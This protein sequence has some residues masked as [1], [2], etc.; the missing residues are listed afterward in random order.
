MCYETQMPPYE[1]NSRVAI[2]VK[3]QGQDFKIYGSN[4]KVLSQVTCIWNMKALSLTI[5]IIWPKLKFLKSGSNF[6]VKV[7]RSKILVPIK[8]SCHKEHTYEIWQPYITCHSKDMTNVKV[9]EKWVKLQG[10]K[11]KNLVPL[12]RSC[13]KEH[14]HEICKSYHLPFKRYGQC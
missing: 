2:I 5:Q 7:R 1:A 13:H 12:E 6:K 9:F 11:V 3:T 14:T 4:T 10:H 8:R